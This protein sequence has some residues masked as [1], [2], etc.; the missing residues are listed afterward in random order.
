MDMQ[1]D[2][3]IGNTSYQ[4]KPGVIKGTDLHNLAN[5]TPPQQL[6]VSRAGTMDVPISPDDYVI[7]EGGEKFAIGDGEPP[8]IDNPCLRSGIKFSFN[9]EKYQ[10]D[11]ALDKAKLTGAELKAFDTAGQPTDGL[12]A[13][14]NGFA[15]EPI[16]DDWRIVV[17]DKDSFITVPCGNVGEQATSTIQSF[18]DQ[19]AAIQHQFDQIDIVQSGQL[20]LIVIHNVPIPKG[21]DR[22]S[23]DLMIQVPPSYPPAALDM[24]W[25]FPH[26]KLPSGAWPN[27][28]DQFEQHGGVNWQ[29]FSWHYAGNRWHPSRDSLSSH[30]RF[31]MTRLSQLQ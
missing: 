14:L 12:F 28:G 25:I 5:I 26:I 19:L 20:R 27:R 7:I 17:Q 6:V 16:Q 21:W 31:C 23:T 8:L 15:D 1:V 13:E 30:L 18:E 10:G 9:G 3:K 2:I 29:R 24:F 4:T 11:D 22:D